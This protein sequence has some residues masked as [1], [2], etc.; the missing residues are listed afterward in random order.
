MLQGTNATS[1]IWVG[2]VLT[3]TTSSAMTQGG[4]YKGVIGY[5][6]VST[7]S[8][9]SPSMTVKLQD[10]ADGVSWYDLPSGAFTAATA[11]T[12][13]RLVVAGPIG[14]SVRAVATITGTSPSFTMDLYLTGTT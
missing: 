6:N 13:Q 10:S 3:A 4:G 14:S 2:Q 12:T 8:G 7:V 9:T 5:L 11:A 1:A